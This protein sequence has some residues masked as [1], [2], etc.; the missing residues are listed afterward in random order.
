MPNQVSFQKNDDGDVVKIIIRDGDTFR[1]F[2]IP[3]TTHE[4][5]AK[6]IQSTY[7]GVNSQMAWDGTVRQGG[8]SGEHEVAPLGKKSRKRINDL[9]RKWSDAAK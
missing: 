4:R 1:V 8:Y 7:K 6:E 5:D 9:L 2:G 3:G